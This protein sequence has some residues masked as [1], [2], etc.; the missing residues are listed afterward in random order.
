[1]SSSAKK[2]DFQNMDVYGKAFEASEAAWLSAA[3]DV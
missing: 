2:G 1:M 3:K